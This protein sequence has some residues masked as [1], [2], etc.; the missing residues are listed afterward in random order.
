[1]PNAAAKVASIKKANPELFKQEKSLARKITD[2]SLYD[3][4]STARFLLTQ[5]AVLAMDEDRAT[6]LTMRQTCI[7]PTK[8]AGAG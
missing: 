1:M 5:L 2:S 4:N 7:K 8:K 3:W 6:I